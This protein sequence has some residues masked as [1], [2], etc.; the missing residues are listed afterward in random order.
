MALAPGRHRRLRRS[1]WSVR[2]DVGSG[3]LRRQVEVGE[4]LARRR[5]GGTAGPCRCGEGDRYLLSE[6]VFARQWTP[7]LRLA[8]LLEA[9]LVAMAVSV[10]SGGAAMS[11]AAALLWALGAR[12]ARRPVSR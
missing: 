4:L 6:V 10:G 11:L 1:V 12:P 7:A 9:P 5:L 3:P 2:H 8:L